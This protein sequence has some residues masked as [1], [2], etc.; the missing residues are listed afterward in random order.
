MRKLTSQLH[1]SIT[2]SPTRR[3][4]LKMLHSFAINRSCRA[5]ISP[6]LIE[7]LRNILAH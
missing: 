2:A 7:L 3:S 4:S 6:K 1:D 5:V